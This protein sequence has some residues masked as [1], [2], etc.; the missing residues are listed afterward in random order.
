MLYQALDKK[1]DFTQVF[2][3]EVDEKEVEDVIISMMPKI[4]FATQM[5]SAEIKHSSAH[6]K[7]IRNLDEK[8][9]LDAL[10]HAQF[11][12]SD[13]EQLLAKIITIFA[14]R[15][16]ITGDADTPDEG[17]EDVQKID[18]CHYQL[19]QRVF[20][21]RHN[22]KVLKGAKVH[23]DLE[24]AI[25]FID[26]CQA[27][28]EDGGDEGVMINPRSLLACI[29]MRQQKIYETCEKNLAE[30]CNQIRTP[31][32]ELAL[33]DLMLKEFFKCFITMSNAARFCFDHD[34]LLDHEEKL[35]AFRE[36]FDDKILR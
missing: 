18:P 32:S 29:N 7:Q 12:Q 14:K 23:I 25:L 3:E 22:D 28:L 10:L 33:N 13:E 24:A 9:L 19:W 26:S 35:K 15:E 30:R 1:F 4:L 21:G 5:A 6:A 20:Y 8:N 34:A 17:F 2:Q 31:C 27:E 16:L 11:K 36:E